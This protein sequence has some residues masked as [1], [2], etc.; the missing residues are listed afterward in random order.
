[1]GNIDRILY[2]MNNINCLYSYAGKVPV[3]VLSGLSDYVAL[4]WLLD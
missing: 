4:H 2:I 1:M 3:I